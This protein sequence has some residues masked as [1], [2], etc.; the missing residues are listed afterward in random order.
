MEFD[1]TIRHGLVCTE[2]G[3]QALDIGVK[4][5]II[6]ALQAGLPAGRKDVD[7][8]G[9]TVLPGGIDSHCH[10]EQLSGMGVMTADDFYTASRSAA[11]GGTTTIIPFAAQ[12]QGDDLLEVVK[13]YSRLAREK[14][15]IDYAFHLIL[16]DPSE[17]TLVEHLP[18][19]IAEGIT[20]FKVY[21]TYESWKLDDFQLLDV[22]HAADRYGAMVMVHCE[23]ND[24]IRWITRRLLSGGHVH[25]KYHAVAHDPLAE[26]E[27]TNRAI[28]LSRLMSVPILI[29][30]VAGLEAVRV[31]HAAQAM[32]APIYAES[33]PQYLFLT[34]EDIDKP[35]VEGAKF[36][37][38]PP[39]RDPQSQEAVWEGLLNDTLQVFSSDHAPY[40]FDETG[41]LPNGAATT[42]KQMANG[43]PGIEL[44]L[45]LLYSEGVRTGRMSLAQFAA[46]TAT[47][48]A[49]MYGL[50]PRKGVIR[51]G[52]D[53]DFAIWDPDLKKT[54][55]WDMLHDNVGYTP[56]EGREVTGWPVAV[57]SR[58]R[59]VVE[60]E[61]LL[62]RAGDGQYLPCGEPAPIT[63]NKK[64]IEQGVIV[65]KL[66]AR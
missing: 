3:P 64:A 18:Q 13:D 42:F 62:A 12:R 39:P 19:V 26:S 24:I 53:A 47:N 29:V 6:T 44:R 35:G 60:N 14:S 45:P 8:R 7:A 56:Y 65:K 4:D 32:G 41:K 51:L 57:F 54:V 61:T 50:Y 1:L 27:A 33:C 58:G 63:R 43:L 31:I 59:A 34:A 46:L 20:S 40:R 66:F 16:S 5:G 30:H 9:H 2:A 11:F 23:N 10:I 55:T 17:K 36:C 37:C 52:S 38:S 15:V 48:H 21:M 49:R 22:L 28:A 25:P